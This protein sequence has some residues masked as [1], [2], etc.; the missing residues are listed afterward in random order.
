[1]LLLFG[2]V[3]YW[4]NP[5][6]VIRNFA[7]G[8]RPFETATCCPVRTLKIWSWRRD[9]NPRPSD[10]K[11]DDQPLSYSLS[12]VNRPLLSLSCVQFG[13]FWM[14]IWMGKFRE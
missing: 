12:V 7:T 5:P 14:G 1:M 10:Y 3:S 2:S 13:G 4:R 11:P 6:S 8:I 9:L